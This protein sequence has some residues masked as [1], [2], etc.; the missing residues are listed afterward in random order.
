MPPVPTEQLTQQ[1]RDVLTLKD[2]SSAA[3][4][5]VSSN[6]DGSPES[7]SAYPYAWAL[8]TFHRGTKL[9][10]LEPFEHADPGLRALKH[11]D[12]QAFLR[13]AS[14]VEGL[15][16]RFGSSVEGVQ[17]HKLN[18]PEKDQLALFV[19]QRGVA[20]SGYGFNIKD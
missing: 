4:K 19:A 11:E 13:S 20:V 18:A 6:Q 8:P 5:T 16:P 2:P 10:P 1:V 7:A 15:T 12:P 14:R 3:Q 9:P 17:L